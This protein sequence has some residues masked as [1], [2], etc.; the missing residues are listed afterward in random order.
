MEVTTFDHCT[1]RTSDL[2][3]TCRFYSE[4]LGLSVGRR[5][6]FPFPGVWLHNSQSIDGVPLVHVIED[7]LARA[8]G[9]DGRMQHGNV[10]HIA[11][12]IADIGRFTD[13]WRRWGIAAPR[14]RTSGQLFTVDPNG[15]TVEIVYGRRDTA[16]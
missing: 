14:G 6:N 10:D 9:A 15:I 11:F 7:T 16:R 8:A 1:I 3:A 13:A 5:P 4:V 12:R 2:D